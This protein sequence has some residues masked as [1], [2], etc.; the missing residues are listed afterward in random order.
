MSDSFFPYDA[1]LLRC[2]P[3][4]HTFV[5]GQESHN[6]IRC[7]NQSKK[8]KWMCVVCGIHYDALTG[9]TTLQVFFRQ[10]LRINATKVVDVKSMQ[11]VLAAV[12]DPGTMV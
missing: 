3:S 9:K 2:H 5:T 10:Q 6:D 12:L 8:F 11:N 4:R 7:A 1:R